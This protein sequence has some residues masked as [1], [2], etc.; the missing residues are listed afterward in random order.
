LTYVHH[1]KSMQ[2]F[3]HIHYCMRRIYCGERAK[4]IIQCVYIDDGSEKVEQL[5][6]PIAIQVKRTI[7][8]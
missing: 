1:V 7:L 3:I 8:L 5:F 2:T 4:N 6:D